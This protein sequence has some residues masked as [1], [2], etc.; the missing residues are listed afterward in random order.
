MYIYSFEFLKVYILYIRFCN[1]IVLSWL[2]FQQSVSDLFK[3]TSAS[4]N[5]EHNGV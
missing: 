5:T 1:F 2:P 3:R 4:T